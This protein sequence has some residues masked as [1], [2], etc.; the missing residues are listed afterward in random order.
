M[1][2]TLVMAPPLIGEALLLL[3]LTA[4]AFPLLFVRSDI[5]LVV[6]RP[7]SEM[8]LNNCFTKADNVIHTRAY[9]SQETQSVKKREKIRFPVVLLGYVHG[10]REKIT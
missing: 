6:V 9:P 8:T 10:Q 2:P 3:L 1:L 5:I 7:L 4:A